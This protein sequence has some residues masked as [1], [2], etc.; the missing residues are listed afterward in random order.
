MFFKARN[1]LAERLARLKNEWSKYSQGIRAPLE[2]D[3]PQYNIDNRRIYNEAR[4]KATDEIR[5]RMLNAEFQTLVEA[6]R[7]D[8]QT[9]HEPFEFYRYI[10]SPD[11]PDNRLPQPGIISL[12]LA[13][14]RTRVITAHQT[15]DTSIPSDDIFESQYP[16]DTDEY[17]P[18]DPVI[19]KLI[20]SKYPQYMEYARQYTRPAGTT[21][22]TFTDF[23]KQQHYSTPDTPEHRDRIFRLINHFLNIERYLPIHYVDTQ[24]AKLPLTTGTGYHNRFSYTNKAHAKYSHP[25]EYASKP[26]S[27]GYFTN[28]TLES[29][30]TIIHRIKEI[31]FPF[32]FSLSDEPTDE[33]L[34]ALKIRLNNFINEYPTML[35]TRNHISD[36]TG[37]LKV[38][39]VYAVD[40][41]F[42]IIETMLTFPFLVQCRK[43]ECA[44]MHGLETLRG[45]NVFLDKIAQLGRFTS[46]FTIDWSGYDQRLPRFI[47]D[48]FFIW[49][50]T[51]IVISHGY[52]PTDEY[53]T[54]PDLSPDIF[55][56]YMSNLLYFLNV[57]YNN[58][59][60]ITADGY[61]YRRLFC[62]V[63]SGLLNTQT[64]DSFG[65][66]YL[67]ID[68]LIQFGCTDQ[69]ITEI[70]LFIMG[71]DNSAFTTWQ[72][73]RLEAFVI[74]FERYANSRWHMVLSKAKSII[75]SRRDKIQTL[76]YTCNFGRPTRPI[77]KL[78]AQLCYPE[79]GV[80]DKFMSMRAIGLAYASCA[81]DVT[82][83]SFCRDVY[84][85]YLPYAEITDDA[86]QKA[87][88]WLPGPL[89]ALDQLDSSLFLKF[90]S[91]QD[92]ISQI[93]H[94]HGPL[95]YAP[96][97]N[98]AHF[99]LSPDVTPPDSE[100]IAEYRLRNGISRPSV[101]NLN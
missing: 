88:R 55:F 58:M 26:T 90:P 87:K 17:A 64:L 86:I 68:G 30:R 80:Q 89:Y 73:T 53:H 99:L 95:S 85:S 71:D 83:H 78:V 75:T 82:F 39:P 101:L 28:A 98:Y 2:S 70:L 37:T 10:D 50:E 91:L 13:Y 54:Y 7:L 81:Q 25:S 5:E 49:L 93:N 92:V 20:S 16:G 69:E 67:L 23:N 62:G 94:Y 42:L 43:P 59:T 61:A 9:K 31:G 24:Y 14:H 66:I 22:A 76:S 51:L 35:F 57:W 36:K 21:D 60:F 48:S 41:L 3:D 18:L 45:S 97:W 100:T 52:A 6:Q 77:G 38:R 72:L 15:R 84:Y 19:Q 12:P 74:F 65:N 79:H 47:T 44:I 11:L 63:P 32:E 33:E 4:Y 34:D 29:A 1:Y 46:F 96:K 40:D 56:R 8:R 27:K